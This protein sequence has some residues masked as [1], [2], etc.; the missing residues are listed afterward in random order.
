M[1]VPDAAPI[2]D[3]LAMCAVLDPDVL[4][5]VRPCVLDVN[6]DGGKSDGRTIADLRPGVW[7]ERAPTAYVALG[8]DRQRFAAM[9]HKL[10]AR[11]LQ[12]ARAVNTCSRTAPT[13]RWC[14]VVASP[15]RR[16]ASASAS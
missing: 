8:A 2:H 11:R 10:R 6:A 15:A 4:Q 7:G 14:H 1:G 5:D 16:S 12:G 3:A 13:G 9:L